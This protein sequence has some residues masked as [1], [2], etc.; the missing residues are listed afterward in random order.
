[1]FEQQICLNSK[2]NTYFVRKDDPLE[3]E[4]ILIVRKATQK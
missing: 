2:K 1:M 4:G 3:K